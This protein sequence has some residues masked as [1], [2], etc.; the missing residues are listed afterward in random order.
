MYRL[1]SV[2]LWSARAWNWHHEPSLGS[3]AEKDDKPTHTLLVLC[4]DLYDR[5]LFGLGCNWLFYLDIMVL[6]FGFSSFN[7]YNFSLH[8]CFGY[9]S[10]LFVPAT[11]PTHRL[12]ILCWIYVI[13]FV[14]FRLDYY[15]WMLWI[16]IFALGSFDGYTFNILLL[17]IQVSSLFLLHIYSLVVY[18]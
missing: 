4:W 3:S 7:V 18:K 9:S 2:W 14:R 16:W 12:L 5:V 1:R 11:T 6:D 10:V 13:G 17:C 8:T 15:I